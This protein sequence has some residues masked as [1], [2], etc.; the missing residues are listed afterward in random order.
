[1][2]LYNISI[3]V[4]DSNHDQLYTWLRKKLQESTYDVQLLKMLESP[5]EGTT[6]CVQYVAADEQQLA[7]FQQEIVP[8]LH[9]YI[10]AN[11]SEKA[12][13]FES[14]MQYLILN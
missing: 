9:L 10:T 2:I 13:L 4:E 12:F 7:S 3:I 8:M 11:H 1:M 14:K 5:H 6:Y